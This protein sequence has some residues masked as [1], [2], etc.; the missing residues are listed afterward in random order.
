MASLDEELSVE[1]CGVG[2]VSG[3]LGRAGPD[4]CLLHGPAQDWLVRLEAVVAVEGASARAV[5]EVAWPPADRIGL[6]SALRR[7]AD[8][9]ALC[10]LHAVDGSVREGRLA[11]VGADFVE[12]QTGEGRC[13]LVGRSTL[14]AVQS[15][16]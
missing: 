12:V 5:P 13:L 15:R 16:P 14:A 10:R 3:R 11:R 1:V 2:T 6:S 4:W 8:A 9:E 7:L